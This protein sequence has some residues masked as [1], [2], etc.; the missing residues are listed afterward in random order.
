MASRVKRYPAKLKREAGVRDARLPLPK[1]NSFDG[2]PIVEFK[3]GLRAVDIYPLP[4]YVYDEQEKM[5]LRL[6]K[7]VNI[8]PDVL[9]T[10][11]WD[12]VSSDRGS[13][14]VDELRRFAKDLAVAIPPK[15]KKEGVID[16]LLDYK[17]EH[18]L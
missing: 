18:G 16:V 11:E 15:S 12:R 8:A 13:Y 1:T 10:I 17:E 7:F 5:E 14:T 6:C 2:H 9:S 4:Q 3:R